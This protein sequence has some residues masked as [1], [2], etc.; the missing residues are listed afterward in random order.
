M[1]TEMRTCKTN[2]GFHP[3]FLDVFRSK[4]TPAHAEIGMKIL[5]TYAVAYT[6]VQDSSTLWAR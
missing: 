4:S 5:S 1:I 2:A 6:G 3:E